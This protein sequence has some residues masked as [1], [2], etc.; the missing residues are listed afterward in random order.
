MKMRPSRT[1][2]SS[3]TRLA[4]L[5]ATVALAGALVRGQ[6]QEPVV[7]AQSFQEFL[8]GVRVEARS[9]GLRE[10]TLDAALN[11]LTPEPVVVSRDRTQPETV[12][13]LDDYVAQRLS[14]RVIASARDMARKHHDLLDKVEATYG[15]PGPLMIAIWGLESNFG[16]FTGSYPTIRAL[17]TL[18]Y[19]NRRP[20]FRTELLHALTMV[21]RG[22]AP[23]EMK[24]SWAGA[25]GQPQFM[26]SSFLKHAVDFDG[27][28]RIDIWSSTAD[29][30]GSM[31]QYLRNAGWTAGQRWGR[32]VIVAPSVLA[33][34]DR[35]M[36]MR[37]AGCRAI[38]ALTV[39]RPLSDWQ[40]IGVRLPGR[41][42]L[43][44]SPIAASL[45]RGQQRF[46]LAYPNYEALLDYNCSNSY[47]VAAGMLSDRIGAAAPA[48]RPATGQ[49]VPARSKATTKSRAPRP[50]RTR[51]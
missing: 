4:I 1:P 50:S 21:D 13:S 19:D 18:A 22:V 46:F 10:E 34:I 37:T 26:P 28:G 17:A 51:R 3:V 8:E 7:P 16:R 41:A 9:L 11:T 31:G 24:G 38:R 2:A 6:P 27:D 47:A 44:T 15:V 39:A 48:D 23:G 43:P 14:T 35:E 12:Q 42:P 5:A 25:M 32:E 49:R 36:A 45:V 29:V 33:R 40:A 30:F 20:L